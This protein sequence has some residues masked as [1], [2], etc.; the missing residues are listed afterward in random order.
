MLLK[1]YYLRLGNGMEKAASQVVTY[2]CLAEWKNAVN[3]ANG[4]CR[5][6]ES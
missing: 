4:N 5:H 1:S 2:R 6:W 3:V